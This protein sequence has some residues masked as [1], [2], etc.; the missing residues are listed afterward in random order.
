MKVNLDTNVQPS[1]QAKIS[2]KFEKFMR[3]YINNGQNR[4]QNNYKLNQK[5]ADYEKYGF[6]DYTI[7]LANKNVALWNEFSLVATK[8]G[9]DVKNG[10]F[11]IKKNSVKQ[12]INT[13][14]RIDKNYLNKLMKK[15]RKYHA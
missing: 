15:N 9:Q 1:F 4:L 3:S 5:I 14:L 7:N 11:L 2:P 6:D 12:I 10:I 13:F 8:E